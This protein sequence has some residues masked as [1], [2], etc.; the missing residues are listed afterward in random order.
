MVRA[1]FWAAWAVWL[2]VFETTGSSFVSFP[3]AYASYRRMISL[4][5]NPR[6]NDQDVADVVTAVR[7]V[8]RTYRR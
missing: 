8:T 4:P 1:G 6:L 3:V 2:S 5:L 7:D